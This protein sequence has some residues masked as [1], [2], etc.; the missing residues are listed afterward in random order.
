MATIQ[1][2]KC[3][4][5]RTSHSL[6]DFC[7][8]CGPESDKKTQVQSAGVP[9]ASTPPAPPAEPPAAE[10]TV[11]VSNDEPPMGGETGMPDVKATLDSAE[12]PPP[13]KKGK[14]KAE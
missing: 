10:N 2:P 3:K 13:A 4:T 12:T 6:T 7:P 1:C 8:Y 11:P 9:K 14:K 5:N